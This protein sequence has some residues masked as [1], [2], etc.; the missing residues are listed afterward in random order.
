MRYLIWLSLI[1][2]IKGFVMYFK[3]L[4][5]EN[6]ESLK[7]VCFEGV[8]CLLRLLRKGVVVVI[9]NGYVYNGWGVR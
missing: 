6:E 3:F 1:N 4:G 7:L 9:W 2:V 5:Y 8:I